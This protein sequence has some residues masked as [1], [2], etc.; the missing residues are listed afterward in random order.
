MAV[1]DKRD[2]DVVESISGNLK[3]TATL[4]QTL[5]SEIRESSSSLAVLTERVESLGDT[6]KTLSHIVRDGNGSSM[7][8]K[9]AFIEKAM[10]DVYE[11]IIEIKNEIK[12]EKQIKK[13]SDEKVNEYKREKLMAR[14]KFL[15]A[16]S[17]GV[18]ALIIE[19]VSR[20][21]G[22]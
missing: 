8:T 9:I 3:H 4:V 16:L 6:V 22:R 14:L 12:E 7:V 19:L 13:E 2:Y 5:L 10:E 21:S 17:P 15:A 11:E 20:F 1:Q 18:I